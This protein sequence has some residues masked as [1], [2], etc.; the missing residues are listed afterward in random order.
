MRFLHC[1]DI[2]IT[3]D[4]L[5]APW[6]ELGWRRW[7]GML[8]LTVGGRAKAYAGAAQTLRQITS[9]V[10][11]HKADHLVISGD[12]TAYA[13]DT[14]FLT[15]RQALGATANSRATCSV[16]PGNH[17]RYTPNSEKSRRFETHFGHLTESDLPEYQREGAFPFVHFKGEEAAIVGLL[18]GRVPPFPGIAYGWVGEPQL[19]GL[20]DLLDDPRMKHRAVLVLTHHGPLAANRGKDSR[21]H[22]L[23]DA[24]A[25]LK[26]LPGPRFGILHGHLHERFHHAASATRPHIF[27]AGSST[28]RGGE[29]YWVID[30]A[31]GIVTGGTIHA[32]RH[33]PKR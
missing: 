5:H 9:E 10:E 1:S 2:H 17:D 15:A 32:P 20:A 28:R 14:E 12:L 24:D 7:I 33:W 31:D 23:R 25:L 13:T 18:S 22:G 8:E 21:M 3:Q 19:Q 29:G 26:L 6:L 30:V 16:V 11:H 4:Y 27:C